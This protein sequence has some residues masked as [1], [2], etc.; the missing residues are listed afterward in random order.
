MNSRSQPL[1]SVITPVFNEENYL[2]E[3]VESVLAQTY[4]NWELTIINNQSSDRS[5]EIAENYAR[6]DQRIRVITTP[7]F[8]PQIRNW[9]FSMRHLS[10]ASKYC[11]MV[12][13]D[14]WIFPECLRHM[15]Q[16]AETNP[17]IGIVSALWLSSANVQPNSL[18][19]P[20]LF[21]PG[22]EIC[23]LQLLSDECYFVPPTTVL[24]RSEI[25]RKRDPFFREGAISADAEACFEILQEWNFSLI[26][27]L[28]SFTRSDNIS[29]STT[30][31]RYTRFVMHQYMHMRRYGRV[32][33]T[34]AEDA[35]VLR[36]YKRAYYSFL[37]EYAME[38]PG[39]EFWNYH[40]E[41]LASIGER[42]SHS[43]LAKYL[44]LEFLDVLLNPKKTLGRLI[45]SRGLRGVPIAAG[46]GSR[47][48]S[49]PTGAK[50][51]E[52]PHRDSL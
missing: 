52:P 30:A 46:V 10:P 40:R 31:R 19:Y 12:L 38:R 39:K 17:T 13:G 50:R 26:H 36:R 41:A 49:R 35:A 14:S 37:A 29:F 18:H 6:R 5:L 47:A 43:L 27:Q 11:K 44:L 45:R 42:I 8:Y 33:F 4:S 16:A 9:N 7:E 21:I 22:H 1:V 48:D 34:P 20:S 3:C 15:V 23:R 32:F 51:A 2:A 25:V 24:F 28:L